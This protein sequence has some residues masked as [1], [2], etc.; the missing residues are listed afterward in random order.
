M[1]AK[2]VMKNYNLCHVCAAPSGQ[3]Q[4]R[5]QAYCFLFYWGFFASPKPWH[6]PF[7]K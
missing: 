2:V 4:A 5:P 6:P 7:Y 3:T 1:A